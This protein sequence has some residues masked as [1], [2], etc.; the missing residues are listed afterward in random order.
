[1]FTASQTGLLA[2]QPGGIASNRSVLQW[3]DRSG[4]L[5]QQVGEKR[6]QTAVRLC[7]GGDWALIIE[8]SAQVRADL[9]VLN[10]A[11]GEHRRL[12]FSGDVSYP[13]CSQ[14]DRW[15]AYTRASQLGQGIYRRLVSGGG[16][17]EVLLHTSDPVIASTWS[18]DGKYLIFERYTGAPHAGRDLWL[19]PI[20][21]EGTPRPLLQTNADESEARV[22][23]DGRWIAYTSTENGQQEV[24]ISSFPG[25]STKRRISTEGGQ[26]ARWRGDSKEIFYLSPDFTVHAA[27]MQLAGEHFDVVAVTPLF[28]ADLR[29]ILQG[30]AYDVMPDGHRFLLNSPGE[31]QVG[32]VT[33]V[34]NWPAEVAPK[35]F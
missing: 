33:L 32:P 19:L 22:S 9:W 34:Q 8:S 5:R 28:R 21:G 4:K 10:M 35:E 18:H 7:S 3:V 14:D 24:Y 12:T 20:E 17:E 27:Q 16:S 26:S 29:S 15:V 13:V 2:Y 31:E 11:N 25:M 23:P 30:T 1:M 6:S